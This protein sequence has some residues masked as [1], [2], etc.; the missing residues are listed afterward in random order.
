MSYHETIHI[1]QKRSNYISWD[2]YFFINAINAASR[3][4]DPNT[5]NGACLVDPVENVEI[6]SG[7]NGFPRGCSDDEYP[8]AN[9]NADQYYNK[10]PYVVHAEFN[11]ILN[12]TKRGISTNGTVLYLYSEKGF[13]PC[14]ICSGAII[15]AGIKEVKMLFKGCDIEKKWESKEGQRMFKSANIKVSIYKDLDKLVQDFTTVANRLG[16]IAESLNNK[17][18]KHG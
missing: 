17:G 6:S 7:Y 5:I 11:A 14:E 10:Y 1:E 2:S 9:N 3:S 13:Y 16:N 12:A 4:K 15:Q 8:W 18:N